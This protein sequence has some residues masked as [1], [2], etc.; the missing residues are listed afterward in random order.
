MNFADKSVSTEQDQTLDCIISGLSQN[1]PVT[2]IDP[3]GDIILESDTENYVVDQG[4]FIFFSKASTLTIK[5]TVF[6]NLSTSSIYKCQL[7]SAAYAE[8]SPEVVNEMTLT[9]LKFGEQ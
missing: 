5:K 4:S 6:E 2:W 7:K 3:N 1:T 8:F 9:L